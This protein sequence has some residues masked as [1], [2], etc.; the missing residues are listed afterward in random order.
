[1]IFFVAGLIN[2]KVMDVSSGSHGI[3]HE[4]RYA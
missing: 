3:I 1:M 2:G 4:N